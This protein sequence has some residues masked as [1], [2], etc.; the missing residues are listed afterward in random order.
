MKPAVRTIAVRGGTNVGIVLRVWGQPR[1]A[2]E[3]EI[4]L[5]TGVITLLGK[6]SNTLRVGKLSELPDTASKLLGRISITGVGVGTVVPTTKVVLPWH[7]AWR[8][9]SQ[10]TSLSTLLLA[11]SRVLITRTVMSMSIHHFSVDL[12][13]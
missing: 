10:A 6:P 4:L 2:G 9:D 8:R 11:F 7:S 12:I 1:Q 3:A 13:G 5:P